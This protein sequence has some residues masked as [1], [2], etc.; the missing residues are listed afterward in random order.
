MD[1]N[2]FYLANYNLMYRVFIKTSFLLLACLYQINA[3]VVINEILASNLSHNAD[4]YG[5]FDDLI[6][7]YNTTDETI[8]LE[9]YFLSDDFDD[10]TKWIFSSGDSSFSILPNGYILLWA[11]GE[12]FQGADHLP[13]S[14]NKDGESLYLVDNDGVTI[15]DQKMYPKQYANVSYGRDSSSNTGWSF[16]NTPTFGTHNGLGS[17][18]VLNEPSIN[19]LAGFLANSISISMINNNLVGDT[20]YTLNGY[21]PDTN[22]ANYEN[23]L[24]I[25]GTTVVS[26]K[27][28]FDGY[29][30]SYTSS[31]LYL[32]DDGYSLP[33]LAILTDPS[34]FWSDSIGIYTNYLNEGVLWERRNNVQY[35]SNDSLYFSNTSGIRIQGRSS[36][37]RAKK[38]FRLFYKNSYGYDRLVFPLFEGDGPSSF[39]NLVLRS[40]Y[41]DDIQMTS[42]TLIRD[43]LVS[44]IWEKIGMLTSRSVFSNLFINDQYWGIYNVR[45][46]VNEHFIS[47]HLGYLDFDLIRYLKS[48]TDLKFGSLDEWISINEFIRNTD[49]SLTENYNEV[50][51]RINV[52]TF[53]NLQ[54]LII[55]AE[56]R[57]W[58][59]GVSAYREKSASGKWEW[60]IWDMDRAFTNVNW[61]GFTF[62]ND[63][64]GLEAPNAFAFQLLKNEQFKLDYINRIADFLNTV[65]KPENIISEIDSLENIIE[66]DIIFESNRWNRS[67]SAWR[68]NIESLRSFATNRPNIVKQQ[69]IDYFSLQGIS[70]V[71]LNANEGGTVKINSILVDSFPFNG[72][73]FK[74]IPISVEAIPKPGYMFNGWISNYDLET[75]PIKL[76]INSDTLNINASFSAI[77]INNDLEIISPNFNDF[78]DSHPLVIKYYDQENL[79]MNNEAIIGNIHVN[80]IILDSALVIKKGIGVYLLDVENIERPITLNI[81]INEELS[82]DIILSEGFES[83]IDTVSGSLSGL[84]NI[85]E[86]NSTIIV[87]SDLFI[88]FN[89]HLIVRPGVQ[90]IIGEH[91]NIIVNGSLSIEGENDSPIIFKSKNKEEPWGGIE[92]YNSTSNIKHCFFINGGSDPSKGWA[93]TN[94]QPI[95]FAKENSILNI[96]NSYILFSPGKGL[97]SH[98]SVINVNNTIISYVFQGG[99]FHYTNLIFDSSYVLNI[100][101]DDGIYADD[102]NDGFHIDYRHP[103][104]DKAS[105]IKNSFFITGKDD[106]IDHHRA[107]VDVENCWIED[108]TNEGIAASGSDTIKV[109]NTISKGCAKGFEVGHGSAQIIIDHSL[110]IDNI[111]GFRFGDNYSTPNVGKMIVTNSIAYNNNDNVKNHTNHLNGAFPGGLDISFSITNDSEYDTL[112]YNLVGNPLFNE[113]FRIRH[114]SIGSSMGSEGRNIGLVEE[115]SLKYGQILI[116][117]IMYKSSPDFDSEDWIELFNPGKDTI[118][119]SFWL[120]KDDDNDH[121]YVIPDSIFI[122]GEDFLVISKD[123]D[124]FN[125][126]YNHNPRV[127]GDISFGFGQGDQ[128]RIFSSIN[129]MI[130]S[131]QYY[132]DEPWPLLPNNYGPSI[133]LINIEDNSLPENWLASANVGGTPGIPN[134]SLS[135]NILNENKITPS[136]FILNQNFPNPFNPVTTISYFI[137][138]NSFVTICIYD[139]KGRLI[140]ILLQNH[141][142]KGKGSVN[143]DSTNENNEIVSSGLYFYTVQVDDFIETKKM[144]LLK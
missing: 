139:L 97:G 66:Q 106:A 110:A 84:E 112:S 123:L 73:Y 128:V 126:V 100:P 71:N 38:S 12:P 77:S 69:L 124:A 3:Q 81:E 4:S 113:F 37:V 65:F 31:N 49:F 25:S 48:D 61:N 35:F 39:K 27:T 70:E 132:N 88:D 40:G 29:I 80:D 17:K 131:I 136:Q 36:R 79:R 87:D 101:N 46:S 85:W 134:N 121:I 58:G 54:A 42:G 138:K 107:R 68:N 108:W 56:Y 78:D 63:T 34:N 45:E 90:V 86:E 8:N 32:I 111:E 33:V 93:H 20:Y 91:V 53:L 5:D 74:D 105:A 103:F 60:T 44:E 92:F 18:D 127:I 72:T 94:T 120:V 6:E 141:L 118:D 114:N 21:A 104:I 23:Q 24:N 115:N 7:L 19:P 122:P 30:P 133:E 143:W 83:H 47:D 130:D 52:E 89:S 142:V 41:D 50:L 99:E 10:L 1:S 2:K 67:V 96:D 28:F 59:W 109:I 9:G 64:T 137:P 82:A 57:S 22:N 16:F 55:C 125:S 102:D 119:V 144:T 129:M 43:P 15:V 140:K 51:N 11:D 62:L 98:T 76:D 75:N 14:L 117:E 95:L 116:N 26:G 135:L 13:F